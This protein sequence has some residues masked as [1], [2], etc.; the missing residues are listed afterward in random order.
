MI[1]YVVKRG[2]TLYSIAKEYGVSFVQLAQENEISDPEH[3]VV[4]QTIVILN[5]PLAAPQQ[6]LGTISVNGYAYPYIDRNI[7]IK[8][9]PYLTYLTL[10]TYGFTAEGELIG[11]DDEEII[12]IAKEYGVAPMMLLS[13]YTKEG[14]FSN[15]LA[16]NMFHNWQVQNR[17]IDNIIINL[18]Q[19]G[20]Y[21]LDIDFEYVLQEDRQAYIN[22]IAHATDRLNQEG[23][24]VITALAPK[25][26]RDQPGLLYESHD[27]YGIGQASNWVLLMTYEWGYTYGP[28]MAV[29]PILNVQKV[30]DYAITEISPD[31]IFM[32]V[33]NYGYDWQLPFIAG[34]S[35]AKS[36]GNVEAIEI[37][38]ENHA[39]IEYDNSS[40]APFFY[41]FDQGK[42]EH[43]VWFE[44]ARSINAKL[45][46]IAKYKL[47]GVSYWNVMREFPQNWMVLNELYQIIKLQIK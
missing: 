31:K 10:F 38:K 46:L 34:E 9:L 12:S 35:K 20:Y 15:I 26:S 30:L 41:Y 19:K 36:I 39:V 8:S 22:F 37:A 13:T 27:Y 14:S 28:P 6:K 42:N 29:A 32:G 1:I 4:G 7:L 18:K 21:G 23:Y 47:K 2:D 25:I 43:V 45:Q 11:I 16:H 24:L 5:S 33:P 40:Q 3:L 44:D 17:L